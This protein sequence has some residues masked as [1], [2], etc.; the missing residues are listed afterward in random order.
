M[1]DPA[2]ERL[3][4]QCATMEIATPAWRCRSSSIRQCRGGCYRSPILRRW[5]IRRFPGGVHCCRPHQTAAADLPGMGLCRAPTLR[6]CVIWPG[7]LMSD[8]R[9]QPTLRRAARLLVVDRHSGAV[10]LFRYEDGGRSWWATPGGA[11]DGDETFEET[12]VREAAEELGVAARSFL[13]LW[14]RTVE[15]SFRGSLVRQEEHYFLLRIPLCDVA[16]G[17]Q[18]QEAHLHEGIVATRWWS[19]EEMES[20]SEQV[21]PEDLPQRVRELGSAPSTL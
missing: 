8:T 21:F 16:L 19:V 6:G 12:A 5:R 1:D 18:V 20:T 9:T 4:V 3:H 11:L 14:H 10:L 7:F 13:P 15:F 2:A 17:Q